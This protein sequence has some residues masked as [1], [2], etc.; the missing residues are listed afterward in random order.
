MPATS[1]QHPCS[2]GHDITDWP[3]PQRARAGVGRSYQRTTIFPEFSVLRELPPVRAGRACRVPWALW[4]SAAAAPCE[5]GLAIA[6][7]ALERRRPVRCDAQRS[8]GTLSHGGKRQLEIAMC[9]ATEAQGAA[10]RR[11]AGR[12]GRRRDRPHAAGAAGALKAGHAILLVEHDMDAVFR[13]A[14]RITVMVNGE[15]IASDAPEAIRAATGTCRS[16]TWARGIEML[17]VDGLNTYY[18]DSHVLRGVEPRAGLRAPRWACS[19]ATAWARP[20]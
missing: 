20:R 10:A 3:Q 15:V 5:A 14:D 19:A 13:I 7:D 17:R 18:G 1:G 4:E 11:A 6:R 16:P 9:L 8:A 2:Q 12:H